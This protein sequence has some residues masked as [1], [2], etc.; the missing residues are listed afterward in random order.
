MN[1]H[2]LPYN[3]TYELGVGINKL[4]GEAGGS[5]FSDFQ[6]HDSF[7]GRG[8]SVFF[9]LQKVESTEHLNEML[10][11]SV[12]TSGR[13]GLFS[14]AGKFK[15]SKESN[16]NSNSLFILLSVVVQNAAKHIG[17]HYTLNEQ[18]MQVL[19][20]GK[21]DRFKRGFGDSFIEG[22]VTGGEF[23]V[24]YEFYTM[25]KNSKSL[26][27][28]QMSG[29]Y[30]AVLAD[31]EADVEVKSEIQKAYSEKN[32]KITS[33][34]TG[35]KGIEVQHTPEGIM[36]IVKDFPKLVDGDF[37][38]PFQVL[39]KSYET[40]ILPEEPNYIDI[41]NK[42]YV[43]NSYAKDIVS[44]RQKVSEIKYI[45][46]NPDEFI[47]SDPENM[48]KSVL[49]EKEID[50]LNIQLGNIIDNMNEY[51]QEA[52]KCANSISECKAFKPSKTI[53][54]KLPERKGALEHVILYDQINYRGKPYYLSIGGYDKPEYF[55]NDKIK[56]IRVP[57]GLK[58]ILYQHW[59]Y[60]L[61]PENYGF[62]DRRKLPLKGESCPD[63]SQYT[64]SDIVSSIYI[65]NINDENEVP[66]G[67]TVD[68]PIKPVSPGIN[69]NIWKLKDFIRMRG[70]AERILRNHPLNF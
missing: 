11:I 36:K 44:Y 47:S 51:R 37:G 16:Y 14:A 1:N 9:N 17:T 28:T 39:I 32:L 35:G 68:N 20:D 26:I 3:V 22:V 54:L 10:G 19:K 66:P 25:D 63:L 15:F 7:A 55:P 12:E 59:K 27:D 38:K 8:Q 46:N 6:Y 13:L 23:Y 33:Y 24:L 61:D 58:V 29:S 69:K 48:D 21:S 53:N 52:S 40:L 34:C 41:E 43:L 65:T 70:Q 2:I 50:Q 18:V 57:R 67:Y 30:G 42:I 31:F 45:L 56:S 64:F 5:I 62:K 60:N 4:T 49:S